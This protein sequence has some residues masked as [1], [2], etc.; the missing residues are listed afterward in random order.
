MTSLGVLSGSLHVWQAL[1]HNVGPHHLV[2][3]YFLCVTQVEKT[4]LLSVP[5][6][7]LGVLWVLE[8]F[9]FFKIP[10]SMLFTPSKT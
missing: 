3:T 4:L 10:N 2:A 7:S 5:V 9:D 6:T 8:L 1:V